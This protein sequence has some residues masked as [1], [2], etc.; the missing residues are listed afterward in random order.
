MATNVENEY[1]LLAGAAYYPTRI[2]E[3]TPA[4]LENLKL[5]Q[6][7][8]PEGWV[9]LDENKF[10]RIHMDSQLDATTFQNGNHFVIAFAGS[11]DLADG[12]GCRFGVGCL[13]CS[14]RRCRGILFE[15]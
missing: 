15:A 11:H 6:L 14:I 10:Y 8:V 5:N 13:V 3:L 7:P 1:A 4:Q 12:D 2:P 9:E